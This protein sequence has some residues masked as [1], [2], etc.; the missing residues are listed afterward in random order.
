MEAAGVGMSLIP[1][2]D[3]RRRAFVR[4][5]VRVRALDGKKV[6]S[7][8]LTAEKAAN[9]D[10]CFDACG[11]FDKLVEKAS[12]YLATGSSEAWLD[13]YSKASEL[14]ALVKKAFPKSD[15]EIV[16]R[17]LCPEF[18]TIRKIAES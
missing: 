12:E 17:S 11:A 5:K 10:P 8:L 13:S 14:H 18:V 15:P 1:P 4:Q 6:W 7:G 9:T 2:G 3:A 16:E